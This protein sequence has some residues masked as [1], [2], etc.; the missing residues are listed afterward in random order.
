MERTIDDWSND[1]YANVQRELELQKLDWEREQQ[2]NEPKPVLGKPP[3]LLT[4]E[5]QLEDLLFY[6][7]MPQVN[8]KS[9]HSPLPQSQRRSGPTGRRRRGRRSGRHMSTD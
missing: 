6:D 2:L 5:E 4:V 1:T 7:A 8:N 3:P 9:T